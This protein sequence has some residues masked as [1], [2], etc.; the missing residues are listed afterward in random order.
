[1]NTQDD[2]MAQHGEIELDVVVSARRDAAEGVVLLDLR[3]PDGGDLPA[4]EAGAHIDMVL[5]PTLV[6]QYSLCSD[7]ADRRVWSIG[8]LHDPAGRGGSV[9]IHRHVHQGAV[10]KVRGPRNHFRLTPSRRYLFIAGGIGITPIIPMI[11][12]AEQSGAKWR[13]V[14]GGRKRSSMAFLD[15]LADKPAHASIQPFDECGHI[16]LAAELAPPAPD[17]LVYC[18]GPEPLLCAV[19]AR[20]ESWPHGALRTERFSAKPLSEPVRAD[21]FEVVL[22]Q[23]GRTF[24]VQPS[25]SIMETLEAAGMD[26]LC[27]CREGTCG[28]CETAV[29][30]GEPDHRDSVLTDDE[31]A[32]N[33]RMMICVSRARSTRLVLDL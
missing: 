27:S 21:S 19:E 32:V 28:S 26:L 22:R 12:A 25:I 17:T 3:R 29:L 20:C 9:H 31:K 16:D 18:C 33:N 23:S 1:M 15:F 10:I 5:T 30:E 7:P 6:R 4:W 8:V 13:L 2:I 24:V 14:Y 11:R